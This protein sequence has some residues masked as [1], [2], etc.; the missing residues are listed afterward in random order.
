MN[1][2]IADQ[3]DILTLARM[4]WDFRAEDGESPIMSQ[5]EFIGRCAEFLKEGII[6][7]TWVHWIAEIGDVIVSNASIN[8]ITSVP[9]PCK[10]EDRFGYLTNVYTKPEYRRKG[11]GAELTSKITAWAREIDLE[12]LIVSPSEDS[13]RFYR[14][15]GFDLATDFLQLR[16]RSY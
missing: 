7:G 9:R 15:A 13:I 12:L 10:L 11:V 5:E 16:L 1:Y 8:I 2:S 14:R 4:R 3:R 6:S